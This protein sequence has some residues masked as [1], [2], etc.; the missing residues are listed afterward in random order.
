MA[1]DVDPRIVFERLFQNARPREVAQSRNRR[2]RFRKSVLDFVLEDARKLK[3]R[4][5]LHDRR[6][7]DEYFGGVREIER[8][9]ELAESRSRAAGQLPAD[10]RPAGIPPEYGEHIRLLGD[11]MALAFQADLTRVATFMFANAG[12]NR[13]YRFIDVPEGHHE[14]SHHRGDARKQAKLGMINRFHIEQFAYLLGKLKSIREGDGTLLDNCMI[15]YGSGISDGNR[16]N[17]DNLP[18]LLAG[19]GGGTI[20]SGRHVRYAPETPLANLYVSLL[21][22]LDVPVE[23]IGDS[24][25]RLDGLTTGLPRLF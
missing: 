15:V 24:T 13:S 1:K 20:D 21:D 8:R 23:V 9:L 10:A 18:M 25:G 5:G 4:I 19:A 12:S 22:R 14:L 2:D 6:K 7:L 16:H 11:M 3:R 17:H